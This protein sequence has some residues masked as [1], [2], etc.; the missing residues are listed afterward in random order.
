M[1]PLLF[2]M[3]TKFYRKLLLSLIFLIPFYERKNPQNTAHICRITESLRLHRTAGNHVS[4]MPCSSKDK[5][6]LGHCPVLNMSK[7]GDSTTSLDEQ[8]QCL[9][10]LTVKKKKEFSYI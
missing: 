7:A 8:F 5:R 3:D 1:Y 4:P 9:A 2:K 6:Y 10:I